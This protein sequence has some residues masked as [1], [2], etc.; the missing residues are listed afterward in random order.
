MLAS[1]FCATSQRVMSFSPNR[2]H[3]W[4]VALCSIMLIFATTSFEHGA[5]K[6]PHTNVP[7][8]VILLLEFRL[9]VWLTILIQKQ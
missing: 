6:S 4:S 9:W 3:N 1:N 5:L 2:M 7:N 8:A